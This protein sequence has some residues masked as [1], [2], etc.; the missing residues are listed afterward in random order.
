MADLRILTC[1]VTGG[2]ST[3]A[4]NPNLPCSPEEI[5]EACLGAREAGAAVVHI[6]VRE[7]DTGVPSFKLEYYRDVVNR[8]RAAKSDVLI[9]LTTGPGAYYQPGEEDPGKPGPNSMM[10]TA[11]K[12]VAHVVELKPDICSFDIGTM[13]F[14]GG[15]LASDPKLI[16]EMA[17]LIRNAGVKPEIECFDTGHIWFARDLVN[18]GL[19][20]APPMF[21]FVMG[22]KYAVE[23][24]PE[25]LL[26]MRDRLPTGAQWGAFGI[27]RMAYPMMAVAYVAGAHLRIG[28]EDTVHLAKGVLAKSNGVLIE[29]AVRI[30][31]DLGGELATPAQAREILKLT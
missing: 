31:K 17:V 5:A 3:R 4:Q 13:Y 22:G 10:W 26:Y 11:A 12:R 19:I 15:I 27:G 20:D 18:E 21:Q 1:S 7:P 9:N 25:A 6:H 24:N 30:I 8:I 14:G 29:K 16:R 28:L 2:N 23:A